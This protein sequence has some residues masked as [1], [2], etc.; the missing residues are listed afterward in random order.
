MWTLF[1]YQVIKG[2]R[3]R[4]FYLKGFTSFLFVSVFFYGVF[5]KETS[6]FEEP[7]LLLLLVGE[8]RLILY[9]GLGLVL[10]LIGDLIL[11]VQYFHETQKSEQ[12]SMGMIAFG[13]GHIFYILALSSYYTFSYWS[14]L[15]GILMVGIVYIGSKLMKIDF[16][17][18]AF[19]S[20]LYTLIIFTMVGLSVIVYINDLGQASLIFMIGAILFGVSDLLLA[21]IYF[22]AEKSK[23]FI[24]GN[25]ATYYLGQLL[26]ALSIV[27]I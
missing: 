13:L 6:I 9:M 3:L 4:G 24:I 23:L 5:Y 12:I 17:S 19:M 27:F 22:K 18:L 21:P 2:K 25:L 16:K 7:S 11:E 1:I 14:L 26:I 20:Y 10:G 15:I 8:L